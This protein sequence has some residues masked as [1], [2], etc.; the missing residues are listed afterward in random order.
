MIGLKVNCHL[1]QCKLSFTWS[2]EDHFCFYHSSTVINRLKYSV[3]FFRKLDVKT[4]QL[5][6][7]YHTFFS[8]MVTPPVMTISFMLDNCYSSKSF[9]HDNYTITKN[10]PCTMEPLTPSTTEAREGLHHGGGKGGNMPIE[11]DGRRAVRF[12]IYKLKFFHLKI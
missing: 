11:T 1:P 7:N 8:C 3:Y 10:K 4:L 6:N 9:A 5:S 12:Y 2:A